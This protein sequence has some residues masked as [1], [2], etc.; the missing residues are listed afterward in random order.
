[1]NEYN[2]NRAIQHVKLMDDK[3]HKEIQ[4]SIQ[5]S[6]IYEAEKERLFQN[7]KYNK[8]KITVT[9]E[10]SVSAIFTCGGKNIAVL[11]FASFKNPGGKFLD[12]GMAQEECLCHN[13]TLYNVLREFNDTFY[14]PNK[15]LLNRGLYSDRLIYSKDILFIGPENNIKKADVITCAAPNIKPGL[16]YKTITMNE[17]ETVLFYRILLILNSACKNNIDT[18]IL[19]A[20]GCGVFGNDPNMVACK[21]KSLLDVFDGCFNKV[22]FAIPCNNNHS[23]YNHD[24]F[25]SILGGK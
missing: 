16:K 5:N 6:Y 2:M 17:V 21:F 1:M 10:D 12:G 24:V 9:K 18:L 13:S 3:F 25:K 19:G 20:F 22:I 11:N 7:T 14:K 15:K 8:T 23:C 4:Y